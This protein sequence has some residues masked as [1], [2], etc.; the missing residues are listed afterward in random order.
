MWGGLP[1]ASSATATKWATLTAR[2]RSRAVYDCSLEKRQQVP[3]HLTPPS[4][5]PLK[6][7]FPKGLALLPNKTAY[8]S[9]ASGS[10]T[11]KSVMTF[12]ASLRQK[13]WDW[14]LM[15]KS[16][17]ARNHRLDGDVLYFVFIP[18]GIARRQAGSL[19]TLDCRVWRFERADEEG[20]VVDIGNDKTERG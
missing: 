13:D 17:H 9:Q 14:F 3:Q 12:A 7:A 18:G 11:S 5:L 4:R 1:C 2:P 20:I 6:K 16:N 8:L 15:Q 19:I 10:D